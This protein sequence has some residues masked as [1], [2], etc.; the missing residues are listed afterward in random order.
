MQND[1]FGLVAGLVNMR[2]R[3]AMRGVS[4][5][6]LRMAS[7]SLGAMS[8]LEKMYLTFKDGSV[9]KT[10]FYGLA[11]ITEATKRAVPVLVDRSGI[12]SRPHDL[13]Q[14]AALVEYIHISHSVFRKKTCTRASTVIKTYKSTKVTYIHIS[15]SVFRKKTCTRAS[16]V[17]KTH[18]CEL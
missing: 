18:N 5:D 7:Q 11:H 17:I 15:H 10:A 9:F 6:F 3:I 16:T 4:R 14:A 13:L 2:N 8:N 12:I 1:S